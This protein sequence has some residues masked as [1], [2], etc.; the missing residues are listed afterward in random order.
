[1][2]VLGLFSFFLPL[3]AS[4]CGCPEDDY[5]EP[6]NYEVTS[7]D[8]V[9]VDG[10]QKEFA[11]RD[12]LW[13]NIE[14]PQRIESPGGDYDIFELTK[15][16]K[17]QLSFR[18]EK[19]EEFDLPFLLRFSDKDIVP[20]FGNVEVYEYDM[21][22]ILVELQR[23]DGFYRSR[24]GV[25]LRAKGDFLLSEINSDYNEP[26]GQFS[27]WFEDVEYDQEPLENVLVNTSIRQSNNKGKYSFKVVD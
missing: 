19:L 27:I 15:S 16:E 26:L 10:D 11:Q 1:M 5:I 6:T 3:C 20:D 23:E 13:L 9:F 12:T 22:R 14:V 17:A 2:K 18:I 25:V 4:M 7:L 24:F 8:Y 21:S